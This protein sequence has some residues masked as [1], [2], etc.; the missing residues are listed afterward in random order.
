M[1]YT[2]RAIAHMDLDAFFVSVERLKDRRLHGI[3]LIIG[4]KGARGVVASAS[5]EARTFGIRSAMPIRLARHL[6]PH[7]VF[8]HGDY[9]AYSQ[10]SHLVTEVIEENVPLYEKTSIDEFYLD[11]TGMDRFFGCYKWAL[12]IQE[13]I[14]KETGLPISFGL[15]INKL[16]SK[17]ATRDA[18]PNGAKEV[19]AHSIH[20][21]LAPKHVSRIPSIGE[22]TARNLTYMG[23]RKIETLRQIPRPILEHTFGATGK[24]LYRSARGED[25]RPVIMQSRRKSFSTERTFE[26]DTI[27]VFH[28]RSI[29]TRMTE[30]LTFQLRESKK[31][32]SCITVKL[33]YANFDTV[34]RQLH[35]TYSADD[36]LL[37]EKALQLFEKLYQR[38]LR[39]RLIGVRLSGLVYGHPQIDLFTDTFRQADLYQA[40]DAIRYKYGTKAIGKASGMTDLIYPSH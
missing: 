8:I 17:V 26:Q 22:K 37:V 4:G 11:L 28:L 32:C 34:S 39:V 25:D 5:Y 14:K 23:V 21:Y 9:E 6:C 38:R 13:R 35:L 30:K 31:L 10:Y 16:I 1:D 29:L 3:P 18:K 12:M 2:S 7:A 24:F 27:D 20:T 33:R 19:P 36:Q 15:S 40:L